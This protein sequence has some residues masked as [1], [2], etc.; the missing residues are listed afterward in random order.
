MQTLKK[1]YPNSGQFFTLESNDISIVYSNN[2]KAIVG[3]EEDSQCQQ[4]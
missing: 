1:L 2:V 3:R 4:L